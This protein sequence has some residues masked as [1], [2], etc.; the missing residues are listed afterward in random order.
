MMNSNRKY[1]IVITLSVINSLVV[2][3]L[4]IRHWS[5]NNLFEK[6]TMDADNVIQ[7]LEKLT[8][9]LK[10]ASMIFI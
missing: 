10:M 7:F 2:L 6:I 4:V 5:G 9:I 3:F 8:A 1:W